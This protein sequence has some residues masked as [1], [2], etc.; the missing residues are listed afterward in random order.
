MRGPRGVSDLIVLFFFFFFSNR[1][2]NNETVL[3]RRLRLFNIFTALFVI[4]IFFSE[5]RDFLP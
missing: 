4:I 1:I 3:G 2:D 5:T